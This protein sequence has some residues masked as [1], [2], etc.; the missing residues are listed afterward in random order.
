MT[1]FKKLSL[2]NCLK[3]EL[4]QS[5]CRY[6]KNKQRKHLEFFGN[7]QKFSVHFKAK[8]FIYSLT[9]WF[10]NLPI[11]HS[12]TY[13]THFQVPSLNHVLEL[14][15]SSS[16]HIMHIM[17]IWKFDLVSYKYLAGAMNSKYFLMLRIFDVK[18]N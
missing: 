11:T 6:L 8:V 5:N 3:E 12:F 7:Q 18:E 1:S 4:V 13:M 17:S 16:I 10:I 15:I 14:W 2:R 9:H